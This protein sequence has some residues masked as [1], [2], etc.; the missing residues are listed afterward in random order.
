MDVD[1][2][3][4]AFREPDFLGAVNKT[5]RAVLQATGRD[6]PARLVR[7]VNT[8]PVTESYSSDA[9]EA[10]RLLAGSLSVPE[11]VSCLIVVKQAS[12]RREMLAPLLQQSLAVSDLSLL[13]GVASR[14]PAREASEAIPALASQWCR[15]ARTDLQQ[16]IETLPPESPHRWAAIV[17]E[18]RALSD[19]DPVA[20]G[21]RL[22]G[23]P[24]TWS[25]LEDVKRIVKAW[26]A[27]DKAGA[28]HWLTTDTMIP[29]GYRDELLGVSKKKK[30]GGP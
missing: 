23:V 27:A 22:Q 14:L 3:W 11:L 10:L 1:A 19:D 8:L 6:D 28:E 21:K 5:T 9:S 4:E 25:A 30:E 15:A 2:A 18:A 7:L 24:W 12:Y 20:A 16:W 29:P 26:L 13:A 17:G